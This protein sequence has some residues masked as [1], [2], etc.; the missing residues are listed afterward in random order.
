ML[1]ASCSPD[2]SSTPVF[3]GTRHPLRTRSMRRTLSFALPLLAAGALL[4]TACSHDTDGLEPE[5]LS[6]DG[7]VF[8]DAFGRGVSFQGFAGSNTNALHI[9]S[10]VHHAGIASIRLTVP[11]PNDPAGSYAG[12]AF[13]A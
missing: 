1:R 7:T 3:G 10:T 11:Q 13:V 2:S 8:V 9:D 5:P 12:G 6:T 4:A